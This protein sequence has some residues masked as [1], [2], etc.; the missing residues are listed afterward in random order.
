MKLLERHRLDQEIEITRITSRI[1]A[2]AHEV[3]TPIP[4]ISWRHYIS[5]VVL[6]KRIGI[7]QLILLSTVLIFMALTRGSRGDPV[8]ESAKIVNFFRR[9]AGSVFH[10][11]LR[12]RNEWM[13]GF[14]TGGIRA[15]SG[16]GYYFHT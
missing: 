14:R 15:F 4:T 11:S 10:R 12:T 6:E 3:C 8:V 16:P 13:S 7:A 1:D 2:L 5:Q 9:E